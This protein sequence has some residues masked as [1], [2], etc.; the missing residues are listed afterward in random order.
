MVLKLAGKSKFARILTASMKSGMINDSFVWFDQMK[1]KLRKLKSLQRRVSLSKIKAKFWLYLSVGLLVSVVVGFLSVVVV[2]AWYSK[3][4]PSP[5]KLVRREGFST[6]I[7]D[8]SGEVIYDVY[9]EVKRIP[10][11][12]EEIPDWLKLATISIEDKEFYTHPGFSVRGMIRAVY[13]IAIH[14]K[15]QGG[16]TLTQQLIKNALLTS[17]R[18]VSRKIKEFVL[19]LQTERKYSKDEILLMYLNEAPYGG[20][21][22]G[23]GAA[24]E[25]YFG[26]D[27]SDL[28]LVESAILAGLPQSPTAYSPFGS[29]ENAYAERAKQVLKRMEE[30]GHISSEERDEAV[31]QLDNVEFRES[32]TFYDAPH[33]VEHVR[34]LLVE[35][36]G[37]NVVSQGGLTVTTSLDLELQRKA[38]DVVSEEISSVESLNITNGA[39]VVMDPETGEILAMV[40]S[41]DFSSED[42]PGKFNVV[43]QGLRQPGSAIKPVTYATAFERGFSPSSLIMDV[44]TVFPSVGQKDYI[45]VNYDGNYNGPMSLRNALGN[46][47][48]VPAVKLLAMVGIKNMLEKANQMG[49]TTLAPTKENL[50][51]FGLAVTLGGGE[52]RLID[53]A[54]SYSS[55]ANGGFKKDPVAILKVEDN[56]GKVLEEYK[57]ANGKQVLSPEVAFLI[58]DILSDN[59]AREITF[60]LSSGLNISGY[61]VAVKTG[62]T[63]DKRDNWAIGWT[64][65][66][67]VGVWVGNND[68]SPMKK[69]ASGV[70]G[71]TPIWRKI[72]TES[73]KGRPKKSFEP[74]EKIITAEVDSV[75]GYRAHD[76]FPT[77]S[78]YFIK[79][80]EPSGTDPFHQKLKLCRGQNKLA[81][82]AQIA[83]GDYEEKEFFTFKEE[84]PVS[85]DGKNRWQEGI[86]AWMFAKEDE[87]YHPPGE[88]CEGGQITISLISPE[89]EST[90]DN[91]FMIKAFVDSINSISEV[92]I[93]VNDEEKAVFHQKPF[94][95]EVDLSDGKY[96]I[97]A[98]AKDDEG[99]QAE[100][101]AK[102]GVNIAWDWQPSP[103]PTPTPTEPAPSLTPTV[104][105]SPTASPTTTIAP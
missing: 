80:T 44:E 98:T 41:K 81:T 60:G 7:N 92:K 42:I 94:E 20:P 86:L 27:V 38:Q 11:S 55:F 78:D 17:E 16:S 88:Y 72:I 3:D 91:K 48:N 37:E 76:G 6:R 95:K 53:L 47:I 73:L 25:Q 2:F 65:N 13:N 104:T 57:P 39:V 45:P 51:R 97:K 35:R 33:F 75:S 52:V 43:T 84:D 46:S 93:Y 28:N 68:N 8:R 70:S 74:T 99:N 87:R 31:S 14:K 89:N 29:Q 71:A 105:L 77:K 22:W 66:I 79:G 12:W 67:L 4:L 102:I 82:P 24:A 62:T 63:N 64:P 90:T 21:L 36:Y 58:S 56:S 1:I 69:V 23:V 50:S 26:K 9:D 15:L 34:G 103:T 61:E 30:D 19:A 101:E 83:R 5:D 10:V 100:T 40:G 85:Q 59:K 49:L 32:K 54:S 18:R 96:T